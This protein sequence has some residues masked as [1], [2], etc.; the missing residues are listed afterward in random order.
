MEER[1]LE[2]DDDGKIKLKKNGE[3]FL[4]D[5]AVPEDADDIVI[6][7]PDFEGF[8]E[9]NGRVGLSDEELAAKAQEREERTAARKGTAE[10]LLEEADSLFEAGDLIGAGEKYLDS[11][12]EYAADWRPWFG[13][14]RVQT[15]DFT[16]FSEI[17]DCQNAYDRAL[18][19]MSGQERKSI[20]ERYVP[21]MERIVSESAAQAEALEKQDDAER[22]AARGAVR[23]EYKARTRNFVIF[24]AL[25]ALFAI[26][27]GV[28]ASFIS[29]VRGM[30]IL[31]PAVICIAAAVVLLFCTAWS[32]RKFIY[33]GSAQATNGRAG[34]TQAGRECAKLRE[35]AELVQSV[36]DDFQK[37]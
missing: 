22:A 4:S 28:L 34:T 36:I 5:A 15:K 14:V 18:R 37:A 10:K 9:E 3:D 2:L 7:V 21:S 35:Y 32:L 24:V 11:A 33:A 8:R 12:A 6:E 19:R 25:F 1:N 20:A 17:Y 27:G 30:Q 16:D 31:I 29:S 26:A 23:A 13:V